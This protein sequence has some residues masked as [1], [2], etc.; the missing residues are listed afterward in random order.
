MGRG[1]V[2]LTAFLATL[3]LAS[4][5]TADDSIPTV[6][7]RPTVGTVFKTTCD[8]TAKITKGGPQ[9]SPGITSCLKVREVTTESGC[10]TVNGIAYRL[11]NVRQSIFNRQYRGNAARHGLNGVEVVGDYEDVV[12]PHAKLL[13]EDPD[14]H[15]LGSFQVYFADESCS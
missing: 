1:P 11:Y 3:M 7:V 8:F 15:F 10:D 12:R 9:P 4:A 5:A 2:L 6:D 14:S 13:A